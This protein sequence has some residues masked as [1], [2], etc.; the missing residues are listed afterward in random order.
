MTPQDEFNYSYYHGLIVKLSGDIGFNYTYYDC[1]KLNY[2]STH[3]EFDDQIGYAYETPFD[4]YFRIQELTYGSELFTLP[5]TSSIMCYDLVTTYHVIK[6]R[7]SWKNEKFAKKAVIDTLEYI[8]NNAKTEKVLLYL[9]CNAIIM[10]INILNTP[11]IF[12]IDKEKIDIGL[13]KIHNQINKLYPKV[14]LYLEM[15]D[16]SQYFAYP[17]YIL[18]DGKNYTKTHYSLDKTLKI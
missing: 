17:K 2:L 8:Y 14:K 9:W 3:D 18:E 6:N 12:Y 13:E 5:S 7:L 4:D 15:L 11:E 10:G 16:D 1:G